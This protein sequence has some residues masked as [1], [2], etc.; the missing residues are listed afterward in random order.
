MRSRS[1]RAFG[2]ITQTPNNSEAKILQSRDMM[3]QEAHEQLE[4]GG[5]FACF[6]QLERARYW[7]KHA[8]D[9]TIKD[10]VSQIDF[11]GNIARVRVYCR[12]SYH[13]FAGYSRHAANG[14]G[15]VFEYHGDDLISDRCGGHRPRSSHVLGEIREENAAGCFELAK[16]EYIEALWVWCADKARVIKSHVNELGFLGVDVIAALRFR[17]N[18]GRLSKIFGG[19]RTGTCQLFESNGSRRLVSFCHFL[20]AHPVSFYPSFPLFQRSQRK[21][22]I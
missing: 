19:E 7:H 22:R 9:D 15:L 13:L 20:L 17:T 11:R 4:Q 21:T 5:P 18:T 6:S 1:R 12:P 14:I 10:F 3:Q 8:D 16:G 2:I